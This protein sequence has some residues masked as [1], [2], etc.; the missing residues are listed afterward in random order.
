MF[1][2]VIEGTLLGDGTMD[3]VAL[4]GQVVARVPDSGAL[5]LV[6]A[7]DYARECRPDRRPL[8]ERI[9]LLRELAARYLGD[10]R[11][12]HVQAISGTPTHYLEESRAAAREW[13]DRLE[14]FVE[15]VDRFS[16]LRDGVS[17][18]QR[19][20]VSPHVVI[21]A[22]NFEIVEP[23][24]LLGQYFLSGTHFIVRP[25]K[26]DIGSHV[27]MEH[28]L[29][30]GITDAGQKL[31]WSHVTQPT[32][33]QALLEGTPG[34]SVFASDATWEAVTRIVIPRR[35][36]DEILDL[37]GS[38]NA[39]RYGSG[40]AA[41]LV[42]DTADLADAASGIAWAALANR[43]NK[44]WAISTVLVD[45]RVHDD[46][47]DHL[48]AAAATLETRGLPRVPATLAAAGADHLPP[49]PVAGGPEA[50]GG[51]YRLLVYTDPSARFLLKQEVSLPVVGVIP[52]R[53]LGEAVRLLDE[54]L[55][56]RHRV[57]LLSLAFFGEDAQRD[58]VARYVPAHRVTL[59]ERPTIDLF[60]PHEGTFFLLDPSVPS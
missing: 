56:A 15:I 44:C 60:A 59:N 30:L 9:H 24:Y 29:D 41:A 49:D 40:Y 43:G 16:Q 25:S 13:I 12:E 35:D 51:G 21:A 26:N 22:G 8:A 33:V 11:L 7:L 31:T 18:Q 1:G 48:L 54:G 38:R 23:L 37:A 20:V 17:L 55:H 28:L 2:N 10:P 14:E 6:A 42:S 32:L 5:D 4:D 36:E 47:V 45:E 53:G 3:V 46:F 50:A 39:H 27:L 57:A 52:Y 58:Y 19:T 34:F